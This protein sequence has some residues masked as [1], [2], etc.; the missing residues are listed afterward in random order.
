M[1]NGSSFRAFFR[2]IAID[3]GCRNSG[4]LMEPGADD[5]F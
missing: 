1:Q 4:N 5:F 2:N 3:G